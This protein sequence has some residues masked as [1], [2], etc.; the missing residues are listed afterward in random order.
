[1]SAAWGMPSA[2]SFASFCCQAEWDG[3]EFMFTPI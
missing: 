1:M 2:H 3:R